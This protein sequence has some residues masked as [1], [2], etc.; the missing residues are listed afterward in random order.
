[1]G[2]LIGA[3]LAPLFAAIGSLIAAIL[4]PVFELLAVIIGAILHFILALVANLLGASWLALHHKG[5]KRFGYGLMAL[6]SAHLLAG[7]ALPIFSIGAAT[8]LSWA[9]SPLMM[10][11]SL[12][13]LLLSAILVLATQE[14]SP[15]HEKRKEKSAP[16]QPQSAPVAASPVQTA[17]FQSSSIHAARELVTHGMIIL[18][19]LALCWASSPSAR[20]KPSANPCGTASATAPWQNTRKPSAKRGRAAP[21]KPSPSAKSTLATGYAPNTPARAATNHSATSGQE[22]EIPSFL[23]SRA[24]QSAPNC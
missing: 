5:F 10:L 15:E 11:I 3:I 1:M 4:A 22:Q 24:V 8:L 21:K 14:A 19:G 6:T 12:V 9:F 16:P 23:P 20:L 13:L 18:F 7:I 17:A 2:D